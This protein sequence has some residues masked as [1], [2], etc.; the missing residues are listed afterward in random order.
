MGLPFAKGRGK[1][2]QER[3]GEGVISLVRDLLNL[4]HLSGA[5]F[6]AGYTSQPELGRSGQEI[7]VWESSPYRKWV[8]PWGRMKSLRKCIARRKLPKDFP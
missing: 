3:V 4:S 8:K 1:P 2:Q 7:Q 6:T 5:P